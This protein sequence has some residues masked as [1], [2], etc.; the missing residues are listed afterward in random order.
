MLPSYHPSCYL[1][2]TPHFSFY[3]Q[4]HTTGM[5]IPQAAIVSIAIVSSMTI[6][7]VRCCHGHGH[8]AYIYIYDIPQ[9]AGARAV[10]TLGKDLVFRDYA[11][12]AYR[13]RGIGKGQTLVL[14]VPPE[15]RNLPII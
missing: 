12:A 13:M 5:D 7:S 4:V 6:V 15:V 10:L 1:V 14:F 2:I 3:D 9:A 11:Q 8:P